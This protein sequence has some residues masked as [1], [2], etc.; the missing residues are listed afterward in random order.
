M[1]LS[2]TSAAD[3]D[4]RRPIRRVIR[5]GAP[6]YLLLATTCVAAMAIVL[7]FAGRQRVIAISGATP[8]SAHVVNLNTAA[9]LEQ[10][11][12]ALGAAFP[13]DHDRRFA[14]GALFQFLA[15][16]RSAGRTLPNV[17]ALAHIRV[18]ATAITRRPATRP[19]T[20]SARP[21]FRATS[22]TP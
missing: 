14:A 17:G 15:D 3:R 16:E 1:G 8:V 20:S 2:Y 6:D 5:F 12:P 10:L 19:S 7:A 11:M 21:R 13:N 4:E 9:D 18:S 22:T